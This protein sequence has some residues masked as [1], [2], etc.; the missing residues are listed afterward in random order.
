MAFAISNSLPPVN[1][2]HFDRQ[3]FFKI[4]NTGSELFKIR[5]QS[6]LQEVG[7]DIFGNNNAVAI[8]QEV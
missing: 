8:D 1:G 2:S 3:V 7:T 4:S 5:L 6:T